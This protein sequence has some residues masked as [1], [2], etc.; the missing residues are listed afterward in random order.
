MGLTVERLID[1]HIFKNQTALVDRYITDDMRN[2]D[3][4]ETNF[5]N[6]QD[7]DVE[8]NDEDEVVIREPYEYWLID[9][10]L[11]EKLEEVGAVVFTPNDWDY[12]YGRCETGQ[13]LTLDYYLNKVVEKY[14]V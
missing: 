8:E 7:P 6:L 11:Y 4:I 10:W 3:F 13:S 9:Q 12:Y 5:V 2:W 14:N 1:I